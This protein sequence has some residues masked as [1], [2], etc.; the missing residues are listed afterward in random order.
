MLPPINKFDFHLKLED[1]KQTT[2]IEQSTQTINSPLE[3]TIETPDSGYASDVSEV[4]QCKLNFKLPLNTEPNSSLL[5]PRSLKESMRPRSL[6]GILSPRSSKPITPPTTPKAQVNKEHKLQKKENTWPTIESLKLE[7]NILNNKN[8]NNNN[9]THNNN[10]N[11][12]N[13]SS[14]LAPE[15]ISPKPSFKDKFLKLISKYAFFE[16]DDTTLLNIAFKDNL[17]PS[18]I[19]INELLELNRNSNDINN[20]N[21]D[22][23][24]KLFEE[25]IPTN[26]IENKKRVRQKNPSKTKKKKH[27]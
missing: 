26:P 19:L 22:I 21:K 11:N 5:T 13:N 8:N 20:P 25:R 9:N 6:S 1:I 16:Q 4:K 7:A 2:N 18:G 23:L 10:N 15:S 12:I 17:K 3:I 14:T 24:H 27:P